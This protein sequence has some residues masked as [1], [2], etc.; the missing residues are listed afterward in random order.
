MEIKEHSYLVDIGRAKAL[1]RDHCKTV[2]LYQPLLTL[3][4]SIARVRQLLHLIWRTQILEEGDLSAF[5]RA[6]G[7]ILIW[8]ELFS[9]QVLCSIRKNMISVS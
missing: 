9:F 2:E 4:M 6:D 5:C 7:Y 1:S 8:M 3:K